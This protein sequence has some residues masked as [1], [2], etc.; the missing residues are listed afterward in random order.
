MV[1][2]GAAATGG[3]A[4]EDVGGWGD[5]LGKF[6]EGVRVGEVDGVVGIFA[7]FG[8]GGDLPVECASLFGDGLSEVA[9]A[10]DEEV[11]GH[12]RLVLGV[13][14][15]D[16]EG[17]GVGVFLY[18][19]ATIGAVDFAEAF[20]VSELHA[21]VGLAMVHDVRFEEDGGRLVE[22]IGEEVTGVDGALG[23]N[24]EG[25]C[26]GEVVVGDEVGFAQEDVGDGS[27]KGEC[28]LGGVGVEV[29]E[30]LEALVVEG[31]F[32]GHVGAIDEEVEVVARGPG[33]LGV[34]PAIG[35]VVEAE[36]EVGFDGL[37][38]EVGAGADFG[39]AV[40]ELFGGEPV[41]EVGEEVCGPLGGDGFV[42]FADEGDFGA[43]IFQQSL[44]VFGGREGE[45]AFANGDLFRVVGEGGK[46]TLFEDCEFATDVTGVDGDV[47][48][49]E[50]GEGEDFGGAFGEEDFRFA[51]IRSAMV[52]DPG[53]V[54]FD[55][56]GGLPR[57]GEGKDFGEVGEEFVFGEDALKRFEL[58]PVGGGGER[59]KRWAGGR[60]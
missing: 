25:G 39:S 2:F 45:L 46:V 31:D 27:G 19:G 37:V 53:G 47:D 4:S 56:D 8:E 33:V 30:H 18:E 55:G 42:F 24:V 59:G 17:E 10:G 38:D 34:G 54:F 50:R 58:G 48:F 49:V 13:V 16:G 3:G 22:A 36:D 41:R 14:F 40:E 21:V 29:A 51:G 23:V 5:F 32:A 35:V 15:C 28:A 26:G 44:Q 52:A 11:W 43:K 9:V 1:G 20:V 60:N 12:L 7:G 57:V 6:G